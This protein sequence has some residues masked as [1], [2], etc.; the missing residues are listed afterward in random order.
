MSRDYRVAARR[1]IVSRLTGNVG[2]AAIHG[3]GLPGAPTWPF[4]LVGPSSVVP[5]DPSC[6]DGSSVALSVHSF[7]EGASSDA[8]GALADLVV[9]RLGN[10]NFTFEDKS[11][12]ITW[13][14]GGITLK[15]DKGWHVVSDF[16]IDVTAVTA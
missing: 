9:Q 16:L 3:E 7:A 11:F 14:G 10:A 1:A 12:S 4:V 15:D 6:V 8:A 2:G 5:F 13:Q